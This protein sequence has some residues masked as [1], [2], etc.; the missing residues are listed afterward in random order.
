MNR[1]K[2]VI[3]GERI[4]LRKLKLSDVQDI[5]E[6]LQ[7][8]EMVKWT[9][10]IPWP[11]KKQ[12]AIKWIRKSQYRLKNKEEYTFGI[13]LKT[14]TKLIG[15]ISLMHV[16]YK[17]KNAEIGYWLGKKYWGQGFMTESVKLILKFAFG[18]LKLHRV[19]ANLFE[20]NI[21][22]KKVLKKCGFRLE[23]RIR[24]CRFRYGKWHN[25]LKYG[26]LRSEYEKLYEKRAT[27]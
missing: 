2:F 23:G 4:I 15:S 27:P 25:E 20:E 7:N 12:D 6:N 3:E 22:S 11:Y 17:N 8:K 5:C 1:Q 16:D 10:N 19:Y 21:A 26:M 18:K 13:I 14:T 24:E 9:L